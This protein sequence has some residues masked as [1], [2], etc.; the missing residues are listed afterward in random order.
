MFGLQKL[1]VWVKAVEFGDETYRVTKLFPAD[2][3][4]G[5]TNQLRRA[6]VSISSNIAEGSGRQSNADF[7]RFLRISYGSLMECVSQLH[8][9]SRQSCIDEEDFNALT[10]RADQIA[11]MLSGLSSSLNKKQ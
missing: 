7:A 9:A 6:A 5:L 1:D 4:F 11:R 2:E 3:R 10:Q 8:V